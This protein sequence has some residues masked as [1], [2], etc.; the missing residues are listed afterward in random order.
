ML[1]KRLL[2][3]SLL[4]GMF[5]LGPLAVS[6]DPVV[7]KEFGQWQRAK[8]GNFMT[9]KIPGQFKVTSIDHDAETA[10]KISSE[11]HYELDNGNQDDYYCLVGFLTYSKGYVTNLDGWAN[12]FCTGLKDNASVSDFKSTQKYVYRSK[13]KGVWV[14]GTYMIGGKLSAFEAVGFVHKNML[15]EV[16]I[17]DATDRKLTAITKT[18]IDSVQINDN[19]KR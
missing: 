11:L 16:M 13:I 7:P 1:F 5:L 4:L 12:G 15:W 2:A 14:S 8:V 19:L 3:S 17:S 18:I 6:S 10:K 9:V